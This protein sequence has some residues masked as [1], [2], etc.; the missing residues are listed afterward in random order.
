[1][2]EA[3]ESSATGDVNG[4]SLDDLPPAL[5][6]QVEAMMEEMLAGLRDA[7]ANASFMP[8]VPLVRDLRT[9]WD[10]MIWVQRWGSDPLAQID[11]QT[12]LAGGDP[13]G[14]EAAA[15]WIDVLSLEGEYVGTLS[16]GQTP[17]PDAFGP[18]GLV[19]FV[20]TDEFDVQT[21]I[22]KR[23]PEAVRLE[24]GSSAPGTAGGGR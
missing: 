20:E 19:A 24:L 2:M 15:G 9:T 22:L 11:A 1:M 8:E 23:L 17:M 14:E 5:R 21:I 16:L 4:Q 10:G 3:M 18:G 12:A 7:L 13:E 6:A